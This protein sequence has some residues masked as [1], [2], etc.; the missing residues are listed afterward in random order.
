MVSLP[1][2]E[3]LAPAIATTVMGL[4]AGT[5]ARARGFDI[6][7]SLPNR[8]ATPVVA[9]AALG[10][11]LVVAAAVGVAAVAPTE[12]MRWLRGTFLSAQWISTTGFLQST[13]VP[14]LIG[15][16]GTGLVFYGAVHE[17]L[18][19]NAPS[20]EVVAVVTVLV[21]TYRLAV[22]GTL[23]FVT[24]LISFVRRHWR[25]PRPPRRR[26]RRLPLDRA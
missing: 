20:S 5:Y 26:T 9:G 1:T 17:S 21:G 19:Q 22:T 24:D 14:V 15:A 11:V 25:R 4:L 2:S 13:V 23:G 16:V 7:L 6:R 8:D 3:W 12:S 18:R 10:P